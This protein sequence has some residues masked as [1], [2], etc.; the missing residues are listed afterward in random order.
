[1]PSTAEEKF[2]T[3]MPA[4]TRLLIAKAA[5]LKKG[6]GIFVNLFF[7]GQVL[8]IL[9]QLYF[10]LGNKA[11]IISMQDHAISLLI[12]ILLLKERSGLS[13]NRSLLKQQIMNG[14]NSSFEGGKKITYSQKRSVCL[15]LMRRLLLGKASERN[16]K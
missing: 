5:H 1:M 12:M 3:T 10:I 2:N 14:S 9:L 11:G 13:T 8:F 16:I 15:S 7:I 4:L 6:T